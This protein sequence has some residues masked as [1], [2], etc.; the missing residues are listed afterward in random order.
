[1]QTHK[2]WHIVMA[3]FA[4]ET[5]TSM[6]WLQSP[7]NGIAHRVTAAT[8]FDYRSYQANDSEIPYSTCK[9]SVGSSAGSV[10]ALHVACARLMSLC[11]RCFHLILMSE[12]IRSFLFILTSEIIRSFLLILT[13]EI[14]HLTARQ[15][16]YIHSSWFVCLHVY[17]R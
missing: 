17:M 1:M 9:A 16:A 13:S 12:L 2:E 15:G 4:P 3:I 11:K 8:S 10:K 5:A 14:M 7:F 6:H